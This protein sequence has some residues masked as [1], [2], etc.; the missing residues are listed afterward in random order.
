VLG[1]F[2]SFHDHLTGEIMVGPKRAKEMMRQDKNG[3]KKREFEL[4][5][6]KEELSFLSRPYKEF[7]PSSVTASRSPR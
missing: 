6:D 7:A 3:V 2:L 4:F 5:R 1:L